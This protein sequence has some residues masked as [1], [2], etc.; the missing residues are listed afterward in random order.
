MN[1]SSPL[2]RVHASGASLRPVNQASNGIP[3]LSRRGEEHTLPKC[4]VPL[5]SQTRR[6]LNL[7]CSDNRIKDVVPSPLRKQAAPSRCD[8]PGKYTEL[9]DLTIKILGRSKLIHPVSW[10]HFCISITLMAQPKLHPKIDLAAISHM[11]DPFPG[12]TLILMR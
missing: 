11:N 7:K 4:P 2:Q 1:R 12:Y 3:A 5:L 8:G 6:S 9:N 10:T